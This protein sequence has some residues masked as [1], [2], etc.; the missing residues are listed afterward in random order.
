MS[1]SARLND[2]ILSACPGLVRLSVPDGGGKPVVEFVADKTATDEQ[3]K[4]A[5]AALAAF[6]WSDEAQSAWELE[7]TRNAA[8]GGLLA[9]ADETAVQVRVVIFSLVE[10]LNGRL[11]SLG[12]KPVL[13]AE[14]QAYIKAH[15]TIG[16]PH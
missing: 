2:A 10:L 16:D 4:A 9:R 8:L 15:P 13:L 1:L 14:I 3:R 5:D 6:D 12:Q 11:E 7:Q